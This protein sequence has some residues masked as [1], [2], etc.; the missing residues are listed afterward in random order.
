MGGTSDASPGGN[1]YGG[2]QVDISDIFESFFGG[3]VGGRS[4]RRSGPVPGDD[5]RF[6]LEVDFTT[7]C[8]GGEERVRIRHLEKCDTCN[9]SGVKP[10]SKVRTCGT[11][12]GSG[13]TMQVTRTPLGS[14]QTQQPCQTCGGTGQ[15]VDEYCGTCSGQGLRE[16]TK[17]VKVTIPAR[18]ENGNKLRVRGEG[19][20]G[21]KGGPA[22]YLY[23]FLRVKQDKRF[24]R[25]GPDI[26][27]DVSVS[28]ID[29]VL[30]GK[31]KVPVIDGEELDIKIP[32][33]TQP[34]QVMRMKGKGAPKL[35]NADQR[36]DHFLNVKVEIP[37]SLS[38]KERKL[39]EQLREEK[40]T[41]KKG[42]FSI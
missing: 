39:M 27:S 1:P 13:V 3:G 36:G 35:G 21:P 10:G 2:Q 6:D 23:I 12:N 25:E 14:F 30:G 7:A 15:I 20:A 9:G 18:V 11:C 31:T 33:G 19:D 17:Q 26:Y 34:G 38:D 32:A 24:R 28:Y 41:S 42:F 37:K 8:F 22:G 29:A 4:S 16:V 5:L 40:E